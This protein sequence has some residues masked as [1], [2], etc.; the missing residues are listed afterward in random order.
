M[1]I[2]IQLEN[3]DN[4]LTQQEWSEFCKRCYALAESYGNIHFSGGSPTN[5]KWQNYCII[6]ECSEKSADNL[7]QLLS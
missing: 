2:T 7:K 4:K 3:T 6:S 1:S 5:A